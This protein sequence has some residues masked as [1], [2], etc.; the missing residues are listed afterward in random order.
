MERVGLEPS[1][2]L[3]AQHHRA[4]DGMAAKRRSVKLGATLE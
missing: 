2:E 1:L 4:D 3:A